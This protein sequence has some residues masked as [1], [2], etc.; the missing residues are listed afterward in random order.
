MP[1]TNTLN[2]NSAFNWNFSQDIYG[3][4][5]SEATWSPSLST[6]ISSL[7]IISGTDVITVR[8]IDSEGISVTGQP[9]NQPN[10]TGSVDSTADLK[11]TNNNFLNDGD[12]VLVTNCEH[13][14]VFQITNFNSQINVV[15][16]TGG[17]LIPGNSTKNLGG[18]LIGGE[19]MHISTKTY[20]IRT[21]A[22][23]RPALWRR[24]ATNNAEELVE[25]VENMQITYG[26]DSD[27]DRNAD[28]YNTADQVN[29]AN[30]WPNVVSIRISLL[31]QS[32][33]DQ[34]ATTKQT[35]EY[36][37]ETKTASDYRLRQVYN[38]LISVRNRLP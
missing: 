1:L 3:F 21:G 14:A 28:Q 34:I 13:A 36:E 24:V 26:V 27:N 4:E 17:T 35:Y 38:T 29:T 33:D 10:C 30:N 7:G 11:V 2:N 25:G 23:G 15:H 20:F 16:N 12:I 8:T 18:C 22:S 5:A 37:N 6:E 32:M 31:L 19:M 9:S